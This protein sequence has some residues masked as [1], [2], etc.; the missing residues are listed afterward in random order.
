MF[1]LKIAQKLHIFIWVTILRQKTINQ[2]INQIPIWRSNE[3]RSDEKTSV[4]IQMNIRYKGREVRW[5]G[6]W[7]ET[8]ASSVCHRILSG[9]YDC[10]NGLPLFHAKRCF[11]P[12]PFFCI[13]YHY[14]LIFC[15]YFEKGAFSWR[16]GGGKVV[17]AVFYW[18]RVLPMWLATDSSHL[19]SLVSYI[20]IIWF[21]CFFL[22][23][24][25]RIS[26]ICTRQS[27]WV[28]TGALPWRVGGDKFC[29]RF[30]IQCAFC[31]CGLPLFQQCVSFFSVR[32]N[33]GMFIWIQGGTST[34][35][36]AVRK[37]SP[38]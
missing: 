19:S 8:V 2:S 14:N 7:R 13:P 28:E 30:S 10:T 26:I 23:L 24:W 3:Y 20:I 9:R 18:M 17:L 16:V 15:W 1:V 4:W 36:V 34:A 25:N 38:F 33:A 11:I 6:I 31:P 27:L 29:L 37:T 22:I 5:N 21:C 35:A 12:P 32:T